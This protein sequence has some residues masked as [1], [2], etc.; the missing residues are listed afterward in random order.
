MSTSNL[1]DA[2]LAA[3]A[4]LAHSSLAGES[5][6]IPGKSDWATQIIGAYDLI[7]PHLHIDIPTR[8]EVQSAL[9]TTMDTHH[10]TIKHD[11]KDSFV[12]QETLATLTAVDNNETS[13]G[14]GLVRSI[15]N[16]VLAKGYGVGSVK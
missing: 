9:Q 5:A 14:P 1:A 2:T 12:G 3:E 6:L 13:G 8:L 7:F 16:S 15:G 10:L 11:G 4:L